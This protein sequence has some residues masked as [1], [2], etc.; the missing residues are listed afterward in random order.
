MRSTLQHQFVRFRVP[1]HVMSD[2]PFK[3]RAKEHLEACLPCQAEVAN[4]RMLS[5]VLRSMRDSKEAA[6]PGLVLRVM[7]N[8]SRPLTEDHRRFDPVV[9]IASVV[10]VGA[11]MAL[12]GRH[13]LRPAS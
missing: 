4:Y 3:P 7:A 8:L 1:E 6:P 10:V 5:R 2:R 11:A 13:R 9:V 12:L